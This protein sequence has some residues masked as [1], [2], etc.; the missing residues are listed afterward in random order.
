MMVKRFILVYHMINYQSL[1]FK[2]GCEYIDIIFYYNIFAGSDEKIVYSYYVG[3]Y[4][5][6]YVPYAITF[7]FSTDVSALIIKDHQGI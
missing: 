3:T 2:S 6:F 5:L 1:I 4:F 7:N